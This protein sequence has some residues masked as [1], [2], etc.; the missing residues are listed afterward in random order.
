MLVTGEGAGLWA[1]RSYLVGVQYR[2][3]ANLTARQSIYAWQEPVIDLP[4]AVLDWTGLRGDE[5]VADIG[6]G[7]GAYLA[8]LARRQHAGRVVGVDLS[9]GMLWS[10]RARAGDAALLAADAAALPLADGRCDVVLASHMLYHLPCPQAA[11]REL[12]RVTRQGGRVVIVLNGSDHLRELRELMSAALAEI[13]AAA[14]RQRFERIRLDRGQE[15]AAAMFRTVTRHD[16]IAELVLPDSK[17]VAEYVRSTFL[18]QS[19]P[20]P[21]QL[22]AAVTSRLAIRPGSPFRVRTHSGCLICQ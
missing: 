5:T 21:Q 7:N 9:A 1:D 14:P 15:M 12:R 17:P 10:A 16:F 3:D 6:C 4:A 2:T 20:D 22:A 8:E 19:L 13:S 11:L 18:A